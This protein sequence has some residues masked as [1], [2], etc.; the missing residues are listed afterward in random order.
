MRPPFWEVTIYRG[1]EA[2]KG[3]IESI[4]CFAGKA[5][6]KNYIR[7]MLATT[8]SFSFRMRHMAGAPIRTKTSARI[9]W[10][11]GE[12]QQANAKGSRF[13]K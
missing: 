7:E 12:A 1:L 10:M 3:V 5:A 9:S 6:A 11:Y 8:P 13:G 4:A 2:G